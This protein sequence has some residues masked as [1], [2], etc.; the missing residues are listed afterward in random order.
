MSLRRFVASQFA[1]R[2]RVVP[3]LASVLIPVLAIVVIGVAYSIARTV[4]FG[5]VVTELTAGGF[6][7][8]FL[9][10]LIRGPLGEELGWRGY[11]HGELR[12]RHSLLKS[13]LTIGVI[14]GL[15]HLPLWLVSGYQGV[16]LI[17]YSLFF[18]VSIIAFSVIIGFIRGGAG[19]NLLY[20][21]ILHQMFNFTAQLVEI[22]LIVV[23]G[24]SSVIYT[25]IAVVMG[26]RAAR[27]QRK[28]AVV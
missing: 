14:W 17:L 2:I 6:A 5:E 21:I 20:A 8:L 11:L 22:D 28:R 24:A 12:K 25:A 13:S 16:D 10:N 26:L 1:G 4:P 23:L 15:W 18:L 27:E 3:L 7:L 19:G 9:T